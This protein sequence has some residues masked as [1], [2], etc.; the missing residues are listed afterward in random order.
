MPRPFLTASWTNLLMA[1]FL[2]D[3]KILKPYT[4]AYT[5]LDDW[6][7]NTYVSLVG[8]HF[9]DTRVF[10]I[11]F[12]FHVN[13]EEVNLRF[14]VRYK[15]GHMWKR[16]VVFI[17]E[18][19]P[20]T[21][22]TFIANALYGEHY[23]TR[24]MAHQ[25]ETRDDLFHVAYSWKAGKEINYLKASTTLSKEPIKAGSEEEFITE[26]YW[27]YTRI[28]ERKTTAYEVQ[29]PRWNVHTVRT[30]DFKCNIETLYGP[31]FREA[32][33]SKPTS[34]FLADGSGIQVMNK[35]IIA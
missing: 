25:F 2:I 34:V 33:S 9:G 1:N 8:F 10:G 23:E 11:R 16:G 31:V 13:F 28:S 29:H 7:G 17:K 20:R 5:E 35:Q 14:Y 15:D 22:I 21:M 27:G 30:F 3:K 19:V 12:P 32:L 18:L 26:H 4:P 6:N 24:A